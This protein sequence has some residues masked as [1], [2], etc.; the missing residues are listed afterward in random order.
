MRSVPSCLLL[1]VLAVSIGPLHAGPGVWTTA[2]PTS[3]NV[4]DVEVDPTDAARVFINGNG[5]TVY[6]STDAGVTWTALDVAPFTGFLGNLRMSP[7]D[8]DVLVVAGNG[9]RLFRTT[10]GG[11]SWSVLTGGLPTPATLLG[12]AFDPHTAGRLWFAD[13]SGLYRSLDNGST[14]SPQ[15]TAGLGTRRVTRLAADPLVADR[16][17]AIVVDP[18]TNIRELFRSTDGGSTWSAAITPGAFFFSGIGR[19]PV[20]FTVT[21]DE[22][23]AI[24]NTNEVYRSVDGGATFASLGPIALANPRTMRDIV[25]HPTAAGTWFVT[26]DTGVARTTDSGATYTVIGSGIRPAGGA[27]ANGVLALYVDPAAPTTLYAGADHTGF[28]VSSNGG[29]SWMRRNAGINQAAIRALAVHPTQPLWVYAG[30]GDAFTT[31]S[32]G[33]FRSVDR[34]AAWFSGSPT[35]E[36]SG[37]RS[38]VIDP[39]TTVLPDPSVS[40]MY[41]AGY[42]A[43][44]FALGGAIRDGNGGIYKSINGGSTWTTIDAGIPS[45]M[46]GGYQ[47]S[48]FSTARTVVLDPSSGGPPAGTGPLQTLYLAGSGRITYDPGTGAPTVQ[49]A[50]IWKSTD[51]GA[52]WS[53]SDTGLPIPSYDLVA[54]WA[55]AVQ[56]VPLLVDPV[57]PSTLY[58]G[59]F[60]TVP[61][62]NGGIPE[63]L[64]SQGVINGVFKSTD[65]GATWVH[66][67]T[68]L[69]RLQPANPDSPI[70]NVLAMAMAAS[71]PSVLYVAVN[72]ELSDA[73]IYKSTDAGASWALANAGIAPDADIRALIVDPTDPDVAYAGSTGSETNPGGVYRTLD[74][75]T[76]WTS[77]SIGLPSSSA[78]ALELDLSG[79]VP[80]LYAGTRGGVYSIDQVPDEDLDGAPSAIEG[81]APNGG[82]G[83]GD[84]IP[85][86]VQTQVASLPGAGGP[87]RGGDSYVSIEV[88]PVTG[89]CPRLENT[90]ALPA[91]AFP[92]DPGRDYVFGLVRLDLGNCAAAE[93]KIT[94][95]GGQ[96]DSSWRFRTYAPLTPD[97]PFTYAWRDL[98]S[99]RVGNTWT[100]PLVDNALGDLREADN[101]IL[102]QGGVAFDEVIFGNGFE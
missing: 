68:G 66:S 9:Q 96:F 14:W 2:G 65:G 4:Y 56:V 63:P 72:R 87:A 32:D 7:H 8:P 71:N 12:I 27:W 102:F 29:T 69:P 75:G 42:G 100:V 93:L 11:D 20:A 67:S 5:G 86:T 37:L 70:R 97:Q 19:S 51:A 21:P 13:N 74:G 76:S 99:T 6:R 61:G 34:G 53:A 49:A 101:A 58:A 73:Q 30:Y 48:Y 95:H 79:A 28:Y 15:A 22:V 85:D 55:H 82:D 38:I 57:T 36:A 45:F 40:T 17:L 77:Y 78:S 90:H 59:T 33:L 89:S 62:I 1:A 81:A 52:N 43:P 3:G 60:S 46:T 94:Y 50:R 25:P 64:V 47:Q 16:L 24:A 54:N 84:G 88:V 41:A 31:P 10:D 92:A 98:P 35:L 23:L 26:T 83:N 39:N 80:R 91:Q 18:A 44:L